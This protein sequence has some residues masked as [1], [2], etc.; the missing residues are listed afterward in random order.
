MVDTEEWA[1][2]RVVSLNAY[3]HLLPLYLALS[4][5]NRS[6]GSSSLLGVVNNSPGNRSYAAAGGGGGT[7]SSS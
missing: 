2:E 1:E 4:E 3:V 5:C 6:A 7:R